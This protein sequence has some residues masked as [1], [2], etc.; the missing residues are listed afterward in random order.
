MISSEPGQRRD[1]GEVACVLVSVCGQVCEIAVFDLDGY[2]T[3][4]YGFG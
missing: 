2:W 1:V 4:D 3:G